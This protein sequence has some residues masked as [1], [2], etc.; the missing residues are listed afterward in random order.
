MDTFVIT[1][2]KPLKGDVTLGGAKN[3]ALKVLIAS[4]LTDEELVIG[5]VPL[6][7]DVFSLLEVLKGL[8]VTYSLDGHTLRI[9]NGH[10]KNSAVP[11]EAGARLRTSSMV[12]GPL[13]AR[14]HEA[15]IPN[16]GGCRLGARPIDR[17]VSALRRMGATIDYNSKDGYFYAKAEKLTGTTI[18]FPKNTHTG[19]ETLLL[20]AVL[21]QGK[22]VLKNAAEEV[23][24]DELI[25]LL[26]A[27]G[28]R[29]KR[30]GSREIT[31]EG[32]AVLHGATHS[33]MPDRNEEVTFAIAAAI[34][35][36][37][38]VVADSQRATLAAFLE[39]FTKAGGMYEAVG[40]TATA[41]W[42]DDAPKPTDI[43]TGPHPGFMTDW[44]APWAVFM[45]Q[46]TGISSIHETVFESRFSY[47]GELE[48]M[49]ANVS[50]FSPPTDDPQT[51]YNFNLD[52]RIEGF[53]QAIKINGPTKLHNAVV[54][55]HD[56]RA[57]ATLILAA[58]AA[59]GESYVHGAEHVDRGYEKIEERLTQ[60]GANIK[61][62]KEE[63]V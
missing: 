30:S 47:V 35:R 38:I 32:V 63:E 1:G 34:T 26:N 6:L 53:R 14:R 40:D 48:K 2:G 52:D 37:R 43:M 45:T 62:F 10:L 3:V 8:G 56:L 42:M 18:E 11:L 41:Y 12:L 23:E 57:G 39:S 4:L 24:V 60:L 7:R 49:G 29:I 9:Q 50:F 13:L 16:P 17:H 33:I 22:T 15:K 31:I 58:L 51:F 25:T 28:A 20:A 59:S 21:A 36:G 54:D 19:T 44:Q 46:A 61:R 5:N 27:M 55:I